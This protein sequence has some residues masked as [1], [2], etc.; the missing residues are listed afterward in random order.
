LA[1]LRL[2]CWPYY[3]A[4]YWNSD[5]AGLAPLFDVM[6]QLMLV[7]ERMVAVY[8][9]RN[10]TKHIQVWTNWTHIQCSLVPVSSII[11]KKAGNY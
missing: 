1:Q 6:L 8:S 3:H 9:E 10:V 7:K 2:L 11:T 4:H 5:C